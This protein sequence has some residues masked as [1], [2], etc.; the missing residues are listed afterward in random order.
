MTQDIRTIRIATQGPA[1]PAGLYP[2]TNWDGAQVPYAKAT[3]LAHNGG[4]WLALRDTSVEPSGRVPDDWGSWLDF[5]GMSSGFATLDDSG[6]L[7]A[8]QLPAIA[9]TDTFT[10]ASQVAML[11]LAAHQGDIAIRTDVSQTFVLAGSDPS[12]L[13]NWT[14]VL[15]AAPVVS[16]AALSGTVSAGSLKTALSLAA[17]DIS[18]LAASATTDATNASNIASGTLS[19]ARLT[20]V[21]LT[22]NNLSDL[23]NAGTARGNLGLGA[24]AALSPGSGVATALGNTAG[25]TGGFALQSSLASYL[26]LA[27]TG[28]MTGPLLFTD[29]SYD[30]GASAATRPRSG[31]F[32]TALS[33]GGAALATGQAFGAAGGTLGASSTASFATVT[34]TWNDSGTTFKG[35]LLVNVTST[36]SHSGSLLADFQV[37][38]SSVASIDKAGNIIA[39]QI[40]DT[41]NYDKIIFNSSAGID[42]DPYAGVLLSRASS[43]AKPVLDI[44]DNNSGSPAVQYPYVKVRTQDG[45]CF[46][47][48]NDGNIVPGGDVTGTDAAATSYPIRAPLSTG[49]ATNPDL[50]FA[51]GVKT[52]SG[53]TQATKTTA[54]TLKGET[55]RAVFAAPFQVAGDTTGAQTLT[56]ASSNAPAAIGTLS[57]PYTYLKVV[58]SD[59]STVWVPAWK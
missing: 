50:V 38:G 27:G 3:V 21:A 55:L 42:I 19:N 32:G 17:A 56:F 25:G 58:S 22:A 14:Q 40:G 7:T 43:R 54:L 6:K 28:T 51:V 57:A 41:G 11:A 30:I 36:A 5:S 37:G 31:Y 1:G 48:A 23:A 53:T 39:N 47:I 52:T 12:V 8:S 59:G 45:T 49:A 9:I 44:F 13:G 46:S 29:N 35:A 24:L 4:V 16:V 18:G 2:Q 26:P 33:I 20:G 15:F 10:V 34:G